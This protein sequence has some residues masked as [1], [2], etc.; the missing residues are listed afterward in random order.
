MQEGEGGS[1]KVVLAH[2]SGAS[3]EIYL[4]GAHVTSFKDHKGRESLF[5]SSKTQFARGASLRGGI[6]LI[7]PQFSD[8]GPLPKH[9]FLRSSYHWTLERVHP[10]S[11]AVFTLRDSEETRTVWDHPFLCR[12]T[13]ALRHDPTLDTAFLDTQLQVTNTSAPSEGEPGTKAEP[14][15]EEKEA[16]FTFT[17][18]LH[19]YYLVS[20]VS[21]SHTRVTHLKKEEGEGSHPQGLEYLDATEG[22]AKKAEPHGEEIVFQGE[23]DRIYLDTAEEVHIVDELA[24][25]VVVLRKNGFPD[26]VI[27]NPWEEKGEKL[28][29]LGE[30]EWRQFLCVEAAVFGSPVTLLPGETWT[31]SQSIHR[32]GRHPSSSSSASAL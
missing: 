18:A 23:T 28:A 20:D 14:E 2:P 11:E 17:A 25:E 31:A 21:N 12:Y 4:Q 13:V 9:G 27:W 7:F 32:R 10:S 22:R 15:A 29:D 1:S 8:S 6:P 30:G 5:L 3:A 24:D 16:A 19:T 26:A